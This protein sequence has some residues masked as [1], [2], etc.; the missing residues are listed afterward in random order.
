MSMEDDRPFYL[1]LADSFLWIFSVTVMMA[2]RRVPKYQKE[3]KCYIFFQYPRTM[4]IVLRQLQYGIL[5][6]WHEEVFT[7]II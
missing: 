5:Q 3:F 1:F 6:E 4:K 2:L 7:G